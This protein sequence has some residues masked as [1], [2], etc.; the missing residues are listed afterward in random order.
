MFELPSNHF[1]K[2]I[3]KFLV[4]LFFVPLRELIFKK[5]CESRKEDYQVE[6]FFPFLIFQCQAFPFQPFDVLCDCYHG[7]NNSAD[8]Y[9]SI[10][11]FYEDH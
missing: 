8:L 4:S 3:E 5:L 2:K 11:L 7:V 1:H 6:G 9:N 10:T